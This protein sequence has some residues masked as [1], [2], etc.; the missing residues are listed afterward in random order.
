MQF[1]TTNPYTQKTLVS[2]QYDSLL[3]VQDLIKKQSDMLNSWKNETLEFR[4]QC[5]KEISTRIKNKKNQLALQA[6]I[7]MGKPIT[8]STLEVE[9]C[10]NAFEQIADLALEHI[11]VSKVTAHFEETF[12]KPE[13]YGLILS[14]QPWNFPYWQVLRM[15]ACALVTGNLIVLKHSDL[16]A[17]CAELIEE[18]T[19]V[20]NYKLILNIKLTHADIAEVIKLPAIKMLTFTGSTKAGQHIGAI[21]GQ[22]LKKQILELGGSDAYVILPDC[23]L[24][25]AAQICARSRLINSGQSCIAGKRFYIHAEIY[26]EFK[27]LFIANLQKAKQGDPELS[28]TTVGPLANIQFV[29]KIKNQLQQ[30]QKLGGQYTEVQKAAGQN[31]LSL[32]IVECDHSLSLF[33]DEE[34][35]GPIA[36]FYKFTDIS[37]V[38]EAVNNGPFGLGGGIFT[39]NIELAKNIASQF[40]VGTFAINSYVQSDARVPFGGTK[41]SGLGREMGPQGLHDFISWKAI[42]INKISE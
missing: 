10:A 39:R 26:S 1:S 12:L 16:V 4:A 28:S 38:V 7:E 2:Y 40:E 19:T 41:M 22:Y 33:E 24:E 20:R 34:I 14:I 30:I 37:A 9:K 23:N 3:K 18:L 11:K 32:G 35:F 27:N 13:P 31:F 8:Q 5:L 6:T 15:A 42:G 25:L 21:A 17:G 36:L 29:E